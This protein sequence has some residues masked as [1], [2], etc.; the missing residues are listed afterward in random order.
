MLVLINPPSP[1]LIHPQFSTHHESEFEKLK[2]VLSVIKAKR[3]VNCSCCCSAVNDSKTVIVNADS[4][5]AGVLG[6]GLHRFIKE[7]N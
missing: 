4:L 2:E 7:S 6:R 5:R 1:S 3:K